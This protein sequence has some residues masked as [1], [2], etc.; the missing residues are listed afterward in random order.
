MPS[1]KPQQTNDQSSGTRRALS[2]L[3]TNAAK[4]DQPVTVIL[5]YDVNDQPEAHAI[6]I[7]ADR[8]ELP[9]PTESRER[10]DGVEL[11]EPTESRERELNGN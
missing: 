11:P 9:E 5:E 6:R 7:A 2:E 3:G 8:I 10:N 1:A 4:G